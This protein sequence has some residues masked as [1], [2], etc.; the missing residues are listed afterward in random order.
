MSD[1]TTTQV[2][3]VAS[4][5]RVCDASAVISTAGGAG[6]DVGGIGSMGGVIIGLGA[7]KAGTEI[8]EEGG[9]GAGS[10]GVAGAMLSWGSDAGGIGSCVVSTEDEISG[11]DR[12]MGVCSCLGNPYQTAPA[13]MT[14]RTTTT[15]FQFM[16][17]RCAA[18]NFTCT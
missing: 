2:N 15:R 18:S 12:S 9:V 16:L 8:G 11:S 4:I 3:C 7:G 5:S 1:W 13:A 10:T 17:C 14:T 6:D